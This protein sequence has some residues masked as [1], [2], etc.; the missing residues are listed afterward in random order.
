MDA[1]C[2]VKKRLAVMVVAGIA[3]VGIGFG[4]AFNL[5]ESAEV[6][7]TGPTIVSAVSAAEDITS[8]PERRNY[9]AI[10][11]ISE[12]PN[13]QASR[14]ISRPQI[15]SVVGRPAS[16]QCSGPGGASVELLIESDG[17]KNPPEY[18]CG[19]TVSQKGVQPSSGK[20]PQQAIVIAPRIKLL[21]GQSGVTKITTRTGDEIEAVVALQAGVARK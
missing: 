9:S 12:K 1:D 14:V 15:M 7:S 17:S 20:S 3:G 19:L 13:G 2:C 6:E 11:T 5:L 16:V 18:S 4:L 21:E 10:V 8:L